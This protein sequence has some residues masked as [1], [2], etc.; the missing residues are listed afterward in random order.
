MKMCSCHQN[1]VRKTSNGLSACSYKSVWRWNNDICFSTVLLCDCLQIE[2]PAGFTVL[3]WALWSSPYVC[4]G[5]ARGYRGNT[6]N[7]PSNYLKASTLTRTSFADATMKSQW[8]F[9][10]KQKSKLMT[11]WWHT[12]IISVK[13]SRAWSEPNII[14][15]KPRTQFRVRDDLM[16]LPTSRVSSFFWPMTLKFSYIV[17]AIKLVVCYI[18]NS[19]LLR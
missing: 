13:W 6:P 15:Q 11:L 5:K 1:A 16:L 3:H 10:L 4:K 18:G 8:R 9:Q 19:L 12:K 7:P 17:V 14:L 2:T